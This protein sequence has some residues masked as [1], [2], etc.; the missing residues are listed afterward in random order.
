LTL[1]HLFSEDYEDPYIPEQLLYRL[2]Y[3]YTLC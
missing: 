3:P 1:S 2:L